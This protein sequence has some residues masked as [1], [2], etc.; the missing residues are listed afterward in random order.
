[1]SVPNETIDMA[2][3][4]L[5]PAVAKEGQR[6]N[7]E[8]QL[9]DFFHALSPAESLHPL[10]DPFKIADHIESVVRSCHR[11]PTHGELITSM[12]DRLVYNAQVLYN[13][14]RNYLLTDVTRGVLKGFA[15]TP[16][17]RRG[18]VVAGDYTTYEAT[19]VAPMILWPTEKQ[20][21]YRPVQY[22]RALLMTDISVQVLNIMVDTSGSFGS[23]R[24]LS[25]LP[26]PAAFKYF[27]TP[28]TQSPATVCRN[29]ILSERIKE[30]N[31][32][33]EDLLTAIIH[34]HKIT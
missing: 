19:G 9:L 11:H 34:E 6:R 33:N 2:V 23:G 31:R 13:M 30:L 10:Y 22:L 14:L 8:S 5:M 16:V 12:D 32:L 1:M 25:G 7:I 4:Q 15:V 28:L 17:F 3:A 26:Q 27:W 29:A 18:Y 24:I 20:N 21:Q